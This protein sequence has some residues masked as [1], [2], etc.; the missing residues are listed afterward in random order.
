M[1]TELQKHTGIPLSLGQKI[2]DLT[3]RFGALEERLEPFF[4]AYD[5]VIFG[6]KFLIGCAT[7]FGSIAVIGGGILWLLNY[8][9]HG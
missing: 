6:K 9:R 8:I 2:D 1:D 4:D 7:I 3:E 5:S